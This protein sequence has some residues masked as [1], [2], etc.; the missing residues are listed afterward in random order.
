[1]DA[2]IIDDSE[3]LYRSVRADSNEYS[4]QSGKLLFSSTAFDDRSMK[5]SVDRSAIRTDPTEARRNP[6]DGIAKILTKDVR[7]C[8]SVPIIKN[9]TPVGDHAVDA[10]HHPIE[11][12]PVEP[13]NLAHS[14]IECNPIIESGSRFRRLKE[15]L[16]K[17]A[18]A[19]GFVVSPTSAKKSAP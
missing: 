8:C 6:T 18:N 16:A 5:P 1:M 10:I 14:Q 11:N 19:H 13:D 4:Y 12:G 9:G 7:Q 3:D 15:A 2:S 17:L